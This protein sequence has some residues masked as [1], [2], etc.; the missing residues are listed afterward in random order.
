M[1]GHLIR[2]KRKEA[3]LKL[4]ELSHSTGIDQTLLSRIEREDRL[5]TEKQL[6]IL[7]DQLR[8]DFKELKKQWTAEK[9][10]HIVRYEPFA[11]EI[12]ELA[13]SRIEYLSKDQTHQVSELDETQQRLL[14][15]ADKLR[16]LWIERQPLNTT[17]AK[18]LDEYFDLAYTY[19]SNRIEGNTLTLQETKLVVLDGLTVGGKSLVEHLEAVNHLEAI[20]FIR[21]LSRTKEPIGRRVLMELHRLILKEIDPDNAGRLRSV[22]VR[23]TGSAHIPPEP[24]QLEKLIEDFFVFYHYQEDNLHPIILATEVHERLVSIH[25]FIDGNGRTAR[26]MMNLILVRN[27]FTRANIKGDNTSR[28][29]YYEALEKVQIDNDLT[30]FYQLVIEECIR[31][32]EEH[33]S[34]T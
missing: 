32:L 31:S 9:V 25:P 29:R 18:K 24:F 22:P 21:D 26:L 28:L 23:I 20:G 5:P 13:E 33:L 10:Y 12:L 19:Q 34:L 16:E 4:R 15:K 2:N 30:P 17:Q 6:P 7:A 14:E 11:H 1:F 27:G 8:I 3:G